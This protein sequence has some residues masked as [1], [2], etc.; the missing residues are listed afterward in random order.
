MI[1]AHPLDREIPGWPYTFGGLIDAQAQGDAA[2]IASH[3]LPILRL[4]LGND[5]AADLA[6]LELA[7]AK[8]LDG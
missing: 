5:R 2:A 6:M 4:R 7:F 8:A 3:D 1:S